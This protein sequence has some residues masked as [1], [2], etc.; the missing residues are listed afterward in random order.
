MSSQ[1]RRRLY[2][3]SITSFDGEQKS[4]TWCGQLKY[5]SEFKRSS[6]S[7]SGY[8]S[9]CRRCHAKANAKVNQ[10]VKL[11]VMT[12]YSGGKPFCACCRV[13]DM[14]FL[15]IDHVKNDGA[16]HRRTGQTSGTPFY[17]WL[18]RSNYPV[19]YQVLC[20][21]CQ[22]AKAVGVICPHKKK[23]GKQDVVKV[24]NTHRGR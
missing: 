2:V 22:H 9:H 3:K 7:K 15:T 13:D 14:V 6:R 17:Y 1:R 10:A 24:R 11:E 8:T 23:K 4:C 5:L 21:N 12:H 19:N 18:R 16:V 20:W